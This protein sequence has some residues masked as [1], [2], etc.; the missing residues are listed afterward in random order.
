M[1]AFDCETNDDVAGMAKGN[2]NLKETE[3]MQ[4]YVGLLVLLVALV[5][6]F[7]GCAS[8]EVVDRLNGQQ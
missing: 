7:A 4:R 3:V 5:S 6:L 8:V 1:I 2:P